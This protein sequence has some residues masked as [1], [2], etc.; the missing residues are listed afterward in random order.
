MVHAAEVSTYA[1][2]EAI[3]QPPVNLGRKKGHV[4]RKAVEQ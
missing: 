4:T 1:T 3:V 2:L